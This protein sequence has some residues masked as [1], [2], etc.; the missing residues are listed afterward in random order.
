ME[1][2]RYLQLKALLEPKRHYDWGQR[3][4]FIVP[5]SIHKPFDARMA[6]PV[7]YELMETNR[8]RDVKET[9]HYFLDAALENFKRK[10]F[11]IES[12]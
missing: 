7:T 4:D 8:W 11:Q 5:L 10:G 6:V 3:L 1:R 2:G 12:R 9:A